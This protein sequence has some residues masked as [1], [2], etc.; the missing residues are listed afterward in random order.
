MQPLTRPKVLF[1]DVNETLLDISPLK[2]EIGKTLNGREDLL[3]LW[4]TTMLQYSLVASAGDQYEHFSSIGAATLQMVAANNDIELS[5]EEARDVVVKSLRSLSAHPEVK[6][7][8]SQ[9]KKNGYK[10]VSY[11]NSSN[12]GVKKQFEHAGLTSYFDEMLSIEDA[13]K[14]KPFKQA[15][16]WAANKMNVSPEEC[17]LV[18]AH[19]WDVAGAMWAGWRAAFIARP[20][21]QQ[22]PL[23]DKTEI[24]ATDL[25][26]ATDILVTYK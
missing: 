16:N 14:F 10:L 4:F 18:A 15:Y 24:H 22:F 19:G 17:M 1:F 5:Q 23:A 21:Q 11:T 3:S 25:Q 13:G 2:V 12:E 8:L 9:L 6:G 20:G 26:K 7:A